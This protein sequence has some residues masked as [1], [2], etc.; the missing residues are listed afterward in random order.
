MPITTKPIPTANSDDNPLPVTCLKLPET[1]AQTETISRDA[2]ALRK[3]ISYMP[4]VSVQ[5]TVNVTHS[6]LGYLPGAFP[7]IRPE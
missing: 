3:Q 4:L 2:Y 5:V 1:A 6:D 7:Q